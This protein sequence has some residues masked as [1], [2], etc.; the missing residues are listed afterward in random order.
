MSLVLE[1]R[2]LH[3]YTDDAAVGRESARFREPLEMVG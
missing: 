2:R 1:M 3:M